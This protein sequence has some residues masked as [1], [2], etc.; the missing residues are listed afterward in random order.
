MTEHIRPQRTGAQT[1]GRLLGNK[2]V[3]GKQALKVLRTIRNLDQTAEDDLELDPLGHRLANRK[4]SVSRCRDEAD[5]SA[6]PIRKKQGVP[7][8]ISSFSAE[9]V[10][11]VVCSAGLMLFSFLLGD[12]FAPQEQLKRALGINNTQLPWIV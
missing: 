6:S 4:P 7:P 8:E 5:E 3:F 12:M 1:P 9:I 10:L 11:I 2:N